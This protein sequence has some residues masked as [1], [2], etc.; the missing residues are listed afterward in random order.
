MKVDL[1]ADGTFELVEGEFPP[2]FTLAGHA[3]DPNNPKIF[4]PK[5]PGECRFRKNLC[6]MS[7]CG[8]RAIFLWHCRI[9]GKP[10]MPRDCEKC[11]VPNEERKPRHTVELCVLE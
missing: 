5:F 3:P 1:K 7:P 10:I 11:D 9:F 6:G 8:K 2:G 4:R